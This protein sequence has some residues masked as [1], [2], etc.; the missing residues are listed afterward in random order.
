MADSNG[1]KRNPASEA[2]ARVELDALVLG[3]KGPQ[4][5]RL[6]LD[7][8]LKSIGQ[9]LAAQNAE[10]FAIRSRALSRAVLAISALRAGVDEASPMAPMLL[11]FYGAAADAVTS[12][13][14]RF[15]PEPLRALRAD[16]AEVRDQLVAAKI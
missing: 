15:K 5:V 12:A 14:L 3:S 1:P 16:L 10:R 9:A 7:E 4:L 8:A 13:I 6:C 11:E 2:Y